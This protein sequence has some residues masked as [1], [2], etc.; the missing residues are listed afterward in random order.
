MTNR[1]AVLAGWGAGVG[2]LAV[3]AFT[4]TLH[5]LPAASLPLL[6]GTG[7]VAGVVAGTLAEDRTDHHGLLAGSLAG[8]VAGAAIVLVF[9]AN[10]PYGVF[11]GLNRLAAT[12]LSRFDVVF[13]YPDAT[14]GLIAG[15]CWTIIAGIGAYAGGVA[16][17]LRGELIRE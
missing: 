1:G 8:G 2:Y 14:T 5:E 9:F 7:V 11:N 6:F 16:P 17:R 4:P 3:L 12:E 15:S 10:E 13:E